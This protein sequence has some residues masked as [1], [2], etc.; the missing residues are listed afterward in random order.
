MHRA[1]RCF[2]RSR[3]AA[4]Q[5]S[6]ERGLLQARCVVGPSDLVGDIRN[7]FEKLLYQIHVAACCR[8]DT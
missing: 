8:R 1:Y 3:S 7:T 5:S 6:Y 2:S 4:V